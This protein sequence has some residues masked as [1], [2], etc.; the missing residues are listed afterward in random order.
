MC[1]VHAFIGLIEFE[2]CQTYGVEIIRFQDF[3][4]WYSILVLV[5]FM[6]FMTYTPPYGSKNKYGGS[7][8]WT[9]LILLCLFI[10]FLKF[11]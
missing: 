2:C 7:R 10:V 8:Y 9:F 4:A 11:V 3:K 5:E 6:V 1:F